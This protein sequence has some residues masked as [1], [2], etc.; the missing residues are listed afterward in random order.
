MVNMY[1]NCPL[2]VETWQL[3]LYFDFGWFGGSVTRHPL[4]KKQPP[5]VVDV[6]VQQSDSAD[7]GRGVISKSWVSGLSI[8]WDYGNLRICQH[9]DKDLRLKDLDMFYLCY[10]YLYRVPV[11]SQISEFS[12]LYFPP[13]QPNLSFSK[14]SC[15]RLKD[16]QGRS[17]FFAVRPIN[18]V[19]LL[20]GGMVTESWHPAASTTWNRKGL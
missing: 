6:G 15:R 2:L 10:L 7:C 8:L 17:L 4:Y 11:F 12:F 19:Q 9:S 14:L 5:T 1:R 3:Q 18:P 20:P 13:L 16:R